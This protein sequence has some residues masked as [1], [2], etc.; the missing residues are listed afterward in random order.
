[1]GKHYFTVE[2]TSSIQRTVIVS[3]GSSGKPVGNSGIS[4]IC[5]TRAMPTTICLT[6]G[7]HFIE[8]IYIHAF[9][10]LEQFLRGAT[11]MNEKQFYRLELDDMATPSFTSFGKFYY[12]TMEQLSIFMKA[13]E[14]ADHLG[15]HFKDLT[16]AFH[17]YEAGKTDVQHSVAYRDVP[18]LVPVRVLH[19]ETH[20]IADH[21]W[22]HRNIWGYPQNLRCQ[23]VESKHLWI[24]DGDGFCR[25]L[26]ARFTD[27]EHEGI[28]GEWRRV[29]EI[30]WGYPKMLDYKPPYIQ[31]RLAE[32]EVAYETLKETETD[33]EAFR[34]E[35]NPIFDSFCDDIF[36][37][38]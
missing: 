14:E 32:V 4:W 10:A 16:Q 17:S 29:G 30:L 18:L 28:T 22:E 33:W 26:F 25:V 1:M 15:D 34:R 6:I 24:Q 5:L 36:G 3:G 19:E 11:V 21:S 37:D 23:S 8:G 7:G 12:G 38:G 31:N 27:L 35:P 2:H 20:Q 9:K 13:L